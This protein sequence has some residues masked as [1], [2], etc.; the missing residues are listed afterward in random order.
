MNIPKLWIEPEY[1]FG[2]W[3]DDFSALYNRKI[4]YIIEKQNKRNKRKFNGK[5]KKHKTF[6]K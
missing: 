4:H 6:E 3:F 2:D 1:Y 5:E